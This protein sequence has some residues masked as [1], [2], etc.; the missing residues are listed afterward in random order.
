MARSITTVTGPVT[1]GDGTS[2]TKGKLHFELT[3]YD[4]ESGENFYVTGP[5]SV[6]ISKDGSFSI[7]L[8]ENSSGEFNSS[9]KVSATYISSYTGKAKTEEF[10]HLFLTGPGPYKFSDLEFAPKWVPT[11]Q[12]LMAQ[13]QAYATAANGAGGY[14][15]EAKDARD[16]TIPLAAQ[17]AEDRIATNQDKLATAADRIATGQDRYQTGVDRYQTGVDRYETN[18]TR[19]AVEAVGFYVDS[20]VFFVSESSTSVTLVIADQAVISETNTP[21]PSIIIEVP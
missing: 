13:L 15:Q 4:K 5:F 18:Q 2:S 9:Y 20:M 21:Y 17:V 3:T 19:L 7:E 8:F 14:A 1:F 16:T 11:N 6:D 12:D 10:G